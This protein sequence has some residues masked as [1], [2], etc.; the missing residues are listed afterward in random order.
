MRKM[1]FGVLNGDD[2]DE[3]RA[4]VGVVEKFRRIDPLRMRAP[5]VDLHISA[6]EGSA[7]SA[8]VKG[9]GLIL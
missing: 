5:A 3:N 1:R 9:L 6:L 4:R 7:G 2:E 8:D